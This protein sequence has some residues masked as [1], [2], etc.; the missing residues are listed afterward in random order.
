MPKRLLIIATV[1]QMLRACLLPFADHFRAQGW[2]VDAMASEFKQ[3]PEV[4]A[5]F[6]QVWEI[7]F[8]RNPLFLSNL[9][10]APK[11][12]RRIVTE[13]GYDIVHVHT[14]VAAFVVR[15]ALRQLKNRP[16]IIYTAH[17]FHFYRGGNPLKNAIFF[18]LEKLAGRWTD[19]LVV[20]NQEDAAAA[21]R[22]RFLPAAQIQY[23]PGIGIDLEKYN[24]GK[25]PANAAATLR[26][27]LNIVDHA[28][29]FLMVAEFTPQ[30]NHRIALQAFAALPN[31]DA[32]LLFAGVGQSFPQILQLAESLGIK[33]RVHFLGYRD[34]IPTLI[35][36]ANAM[37]LVS[38]REG[39]SRSVM[40]AMSL[41]TPVIGTNIR[42]IRDLLQND[43]GILIAARDVK[44]LTQAMQT[45]I[46]NPDLAAK[47]SAQG[48]QQVKQ[49]NLRH[50]IQLHEELYQRA[51]VKQS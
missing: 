26:R 43:A 17:G 29:I 9:L 27:E 33:D 20:I 32:Q 30:K 8:S 2:Q 10:T 15:F 37:L 21:K 14:P 1:P 19:Y 5:H 39:L 40:E 38:D 13:Q 42:G 6:D 24:Q 51:L 47:M 45:I 35:S 49:Y 4:I 31:K 23:M 25:I 16:K 34:D 41:G 22:L 36:V 48:Q 44:A 46:L 7:P 50:I 18:T 28:P 12:I 3:A 11:Q